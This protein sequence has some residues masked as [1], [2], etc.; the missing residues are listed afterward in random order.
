MDPKTGQ[1]VHVEDAL[2]AE[3]RGLV[4][5]PDGEVDRVRR[6]NRKARRAWAANQRRI[7]KLEKK[8]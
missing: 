5:I 4:P 2:E 1:I 8:R 7:E 3:R 6:M